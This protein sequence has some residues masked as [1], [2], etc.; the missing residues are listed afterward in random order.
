MKPRL[1]LLILILCAPALPAAQDPLLSAPNWDES[2]A[3]QTA[4]VPESQAR[5]AELFNL[6]AGGDRAALERRLDETIA[7]HGLTAPARDYVLFRFTVGLADLD[8]IDGEIVERLR[9]VSSLV[10]VPHP[11]R[12]S[13]GVPL[14]NIAGAAE[15]VRNLDRRRQAADEARDRM[16]GSAQTWIAAYLGAPRVERSGFV[17][18]LDQAPDI[19]LAGLLEAGVALPSAAVDLTPVLGKSALLL[20]DPAALE[21]VVHHGGGSELAGILE[22]AARTL[23]AT[24]GRVLLQAAVSDA[25]PPNAALAIAQLYPRLAGDP[26]ATELLFSNLGHADL[27]GVAAMALARSGGTDVRAALRRVAEE[28]DDLAAARARSVLALRASQGGRQ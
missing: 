3:A 27:G 7:A 20:G 22:A 13:V 16:G 14:F 11:D 23:P 18:A 24:D 25:P 1:L 6:L 5:V 19:M 9:N 17:D 15:G 26:A 21:F 12:A 4:Q 10:L 2:L 28:G 8:A